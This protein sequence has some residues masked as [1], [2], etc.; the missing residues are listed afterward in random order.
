MPTTNPSFVA[1]ESIAP[2]L[3]VKRSQVADHTVLK[4]VI[5]DTPCGVIHEGSREAPIPNITPVA[6]ASGESA[7]VYGPGETCEVDVGSGVVITA[8]LPVMADANS[9][10]RRAIPGLPA[11]G[12]AEKTVTGPARARVFI[13]PHIPQNDDPDPIIVL[14]G[15]SPRTV[16]DYEAG[17][18][19]MNSGGAVEFDLP[20]AIPGMV[21]KFQVGHA[22]ALTIDPNG[23]ETITSTAGVPGTAGQA[24]VADLVSES[25][26]IKCNV[27]GA[28]VVQSSTGTW[29]IT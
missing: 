26:T 11:L 22:S 19:F 18:T 21:F 14:T 1:G 17:S 23:T 13:R 2:S 4:A 3:I 8:G 25:V 10:A 16:L 20:A 28:W 12:D 7:R 6:A 9:K 5:G 27:A 29:T 24:L 15:A